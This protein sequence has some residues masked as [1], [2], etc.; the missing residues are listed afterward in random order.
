[1]ATTRGRHGVGATARPAE[2]RVGVWGRPRGGKAGGHTYQAVPREHL[3]QGDEVVAIAKVFIQVTDV[4][5]GLWGQTHWAGRR[6]PRATNRP[7]VR[8][9]TDLR[10]REAGGPRR[11]LPLPASAA[12]EA[13][14]E[15]RR[16]VTR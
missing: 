2:R 1:M 7:G 10:G 15:R 11:H 6:F 14:D 12:G 13:R 3:Q 16:C 9:C 4:P 5:L 8:R